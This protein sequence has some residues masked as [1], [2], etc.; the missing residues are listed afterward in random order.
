MKFI[1]NFTT[2]LRRK[3]LGLDFMQG[4]FV[5]EWSNIWMSMMRMTFNEKQ[6]ELTRKPGCI[7]VI[8]PV[9]FTARI[10]KNASRICRKEIRTAILRLVNHPKSG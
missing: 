5:L 10:E 2:V 1:F 4:V 9:N 3:D 8:V 6:S 7:D